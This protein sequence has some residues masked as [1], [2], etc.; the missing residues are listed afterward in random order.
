MESSNTSFEQLLF[1]INYNLCKIFPAFTPFAIDCEKYHN[2]IMLYADV[3]REQIRQKRLENKRTKIVKGKRVE[4][5]RA[6]DNW[7]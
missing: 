7:F 5:R 4:R 6:S 1:Q 3:R 2:V